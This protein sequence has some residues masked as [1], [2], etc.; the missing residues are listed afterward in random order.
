M[1]Y[2]TDN[3]LTILSLIIALL[4]GV[5]G[6]LSA[7]THF[8]NRP[9]FHFSVANIITG[10]RPRDDSEDRDAMIFLSCTVSN[11]GPQPLSPE[12]FE[13]SIDIDGHWRAFSRSLIPIGAQF[14]SAD[15]EIQ[16][17]EPWKRDLQQYSGP[18]NQ[19]QPIHGF[20]M[21]LSPDILIENIRQSIDQ[22]R[23]MKITCVDI[24]NKS[25]R[26]KVRPSAHKIKLPISYPKHGIS[27][28]D[29]NGQFG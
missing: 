3:W 5:P 2:L 9:K 8:K 13:L 14:L 23:P 12:T 17:S 20:L 1:D 28:R 4:G 22:N 26:V 27:V 29:K 10:E 18:I 6:I 15:Q 19:G 11:N 7:A 16:I 21:F 24:Y 25:H